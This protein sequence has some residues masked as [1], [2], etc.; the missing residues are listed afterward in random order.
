MAK[1]GGT[2]PGSKLF[3]FGRGIC[4]LNDIVVWNSVDVTIVN[5]PMVNIPTIELVIFL[6]DGFWHC[7]THTNESTMSTMSTMVHLQM[8]HLYLLKLVIFHRKLLTYLRLAECGTPKSQGQTIFHFKT[9]PVIDSQRSPD[10]P[11]NKLT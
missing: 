3:S 1:D 4:F 11:D 7:H 5:H 10:I 9:I 2:S 6:G 8:V